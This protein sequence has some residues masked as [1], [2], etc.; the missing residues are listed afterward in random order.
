M[1]PNTPFSDLPLLVDGYVRLSRDDNKSRYSSIENQKKIIEQ[2]AKDNHMTVRC[3][4]EDDGY[5]GYSFDR[6]DFK[7]MLA[8][9]DSINVII[10]KD[11]SRIGRHNAKVLLFLEEMEEMGKRIILIDDNYDSFYSDD[12]ILG[13]KTWDNERHVKN[14]S[15]KV[16]RVKRLEQENGTLKCTPPFGYIRSPITPQKILIDEEA[17]SI[18]H[19]EKDLYLEGNGIRK[20]AQ[21]L[22]E[23]NIPTPTMLQKERYNSLGIP[24]HRKVVYKWN[25]SMVRDTLFNDYHNGIFRTHKRERNTINGKDKKVPKEQ[26]FVFYGHHPKIFDDETVKLLQDTKNSRLNNHYRGQRKHTNLFSGCLYCSDCGSKM[27]AINRP[28]R[29]KY[30]I[31]GTYNKKGKAFCSRSHLITEETLNTALY[32]YL[33]LIQDKHSDII[34]TIKTPNYNQISPVF[35]YRQRLEHHIQKLK[36]E[37][38]TIISQ[39]IAELSD[40][41]YITPYL[42]EALTSLEEEKIKQ[43]K[44]TEKTLQN[45]PSFSSYNN[46]IEQTSISSTSDIWNKI[47]TQ[48]LLN[49]ADIELLIDKI[50]VDQNGNPDIFF[51]YELP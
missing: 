43:I 10:A 8:Q 49:R 6:P 37:L 28:D 12:D 20:I 41:S 14:T 39:K 31:C 15:K 46:T 19:M 35:N 9:L 11:L 33:S 40:S 21:I 24:Y 1:N 18:L 48:N 29:K 42:S 3:I 34:Q 25:Y 44:E 47:I 23:K 7:K 2:F 16:K 50:L 26:Q 5:S 4:Y 38:K 13:I 27:T 30:Y 51:K 17:A 22:N 32:K 36:N 45:L